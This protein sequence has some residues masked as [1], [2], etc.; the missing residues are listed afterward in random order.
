MLQTSN[1]RVEGRDPT[2][3]GKISS[4]QTP[5]A[6]P[7]AA[8]TT[9]N[10]SH[11]RARRPTAQQPHLAAIGAGLRAREVL[12]VTAEIEVPLRDAASLKRG[13]PLKVLVLVNLPDSQASA[14]LLHSRVRRV[15]RR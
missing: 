8:T 14:E 4:P 10:V 1:L 15:Q 2:G 3:D 13:T 9:T 6:E 12:N 5:R 11:H 7:A